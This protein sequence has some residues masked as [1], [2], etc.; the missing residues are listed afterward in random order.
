MSTTSQHFS[1]TTRFF[2]IS[3]AG[4]VDHGKTSLIR[5]LTGIDPDR[6]KEEKERQMTTDLG[7]AHLS[8]GDDLMVGFVDVPGHGKFLKNMLA[9]VGGIDMALLVVAADE[10]PM[11]QTI[12][13]VRILSLLG[14][15]QAIIAITKIDMVEADT[16]ELV[17]DDVTK[18]MAEHS[19]EILDFCPVS[20]T[21]G[22]GFDELKHSFATVLGKRPERDTT[23]PVFLPVDRVFSKAGFGTVITGTLVKG[24]LGAGDQVMVAPMMRQARVRRVETFGQQVEQAHAGQ[25]VACNIVLKDNDSITRGHLIMTGPSAAAKMVVVG[26]VDRP[27]ISSVPLSQRMSDQPVRIYHGTAEC[28]GYLRWVTDASGK[29]GHEA[30]G[31]LALSDA[32]VA[33]PGDRCV[34][35]LSDDTIYGGEILL[36]QRARWL[37]KANLL[38]ISELLSSG[39]NQAALLE[40]VQSAPHKIIKQE[41]FVHF[42]PAPLPET[43]AQALLAAGKLVKLADYVMTPETRR[44]L[45]AGVQEQLAGGGSDGIGLEHLRTSMPVKLDRQTFQ[46]L[47]D[48]E[49]GQG[50][51]VK[52][53]DKLFAPGAGTKKEKGKDEVELHGK[54]LDA[55][56]ENFC[57]ELDELAALLK[58]DLS[59]IKQGCNALA[60]DG[61]LHIANYEFVLND[62]NLKLAHRK[63][64]DIWIAKKLISPGDFRDAVGT[65][66]KYA[67]ALLQHFDD[68]KVTRLLPSGRVLLKGPPA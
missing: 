48:E 15:R 16:V 26:L 64:S 29:G 66:R 58:V 25:R 24:K 36:S 8:L 19:I 49:Q 38:E 27:S 54:I 17:K 39:Q 42:L 32:L 68:S 20:S 7:F 41:Q 40:L 57:L 5:K 22:L 10:G 60:K 21:K 63:L 43:E 56:S 52:Q 23:G 65:S 30:I 28:H 3:T 55:L 62:A 51:L 44:Q 31:L 4:H 1:S 50:T 11:P 34:V 46:A 53:A 33:Q 6:L 67:M 14:V 12:Q 9:G 59:K 61:Q 13:H 45:T 2:T 47:I 35:R 18:M 37:K